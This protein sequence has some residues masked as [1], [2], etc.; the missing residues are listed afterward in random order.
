MARRFPYKQRDLFRLGSA[1][2]F[3][4]AALD[5]VAFPLGGIGAG[6]VSIGGWGQLR[7]WE[8]FNRP[9]KGVNSPTS[10]FAVRCIE[11]GRRQAQVRLLQGIP[12]GSYVG[13]GHGLTAWNA[14]LPAFR[15]CEFEGEFPFARV[16]LRDRGMPIEATIEAWSPFIPLDAHNSSLPAALFSIRLRN[17]GMRPVRVRL[18]ALLENLVGYP[19]TGGCENRVLHEVNGS[20]T[21]VI[22]ASRKHASDSPRFAQLALVTPVANAEGTAR[23]VSSTGFDGAWEFWKSITRSGDFPVMEETAHGPDDGTLTVGLAV[24]G[25]IAPS[26]EVT[27]PVAI[28]WYSPISDAGGVPWR[29]YVGAA[30]A[31]VQEVVEYLLRNLDP[32]ER[33]TRDFCRRLH[34]SSIPGVA[35]EALSSQLSILRSP[36]CLRFE[37]GR[38]WGWEGCHDSGGCCPGTCT[39]VWNYAQA[40]AWLFPELERSVRE[41]HFELNMDPETG[42]MCFRQPLPPGTRCNVQGFHPAADG[43]LGGV[44]KVYREW[45]ICGDDAWLRKVWP[46]CRKSIEFAWQQWDYDRDGVVEGVQHNTYD[47]EFWGP[48]PMIQTFYLGALRAAALMAR[49]LGE[50]EAAAEYERLF[51]MGRAWT[52]KHLFTGRWYRQIIDPEAGKHTVHPSNHLRQGETIPRYQFGDGCLSDQLIGE[53]YADMLGFGPM[54]NPEHIDVALKN[55][56]RHNWRS[57]L[58]EHACLLRAYALGREAGLLLCSWPNVEEPPYPFWFSSEVWCGVEYQVAAFM[59]RRGLLRRGLTIVKGVRDRHDGRRRNPYDEFECGHHYS[60]SLASYDLLHAFA[61]FFWHGPERRLRFAP[62]W[63]AESFRTFFSTGTA[64]GVYEQERVERGV[65]RVRLTVDEGR[66]P[67]RVLQIACAEAAEGVTA[68]VDGQPCVVRWEDD[69]R[70]C[71]LFYPEVVLEAGRRLSIEILPADGNSENSG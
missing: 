36:T 4:G 21:A 63:S 67:L 61:G 69:K 48:N 8:V 6:C 33:R 54:L 13:G 15:T 18:Y 9:G 58:T 3:S 19:E 60:R 35:L 17:R 31:D 46:A 44:M 28:V 62:R 49:H 25:R 59:V 51:E 16:H 53:W 50:H 70:T 56:F 11:K 23:A 47:N 30:F 27:W 1:R 40:L 64:W 29:T 43:Q 68:D 2:R 10:F 24:S 66:L 55:I 65:W 71:L 38:F 41:Q 12:G 7:D 57:D 39:H 5:E 14:K 26:E 37:D 20:G 34:A 52:E 42:R 45:L 22:L 32:L